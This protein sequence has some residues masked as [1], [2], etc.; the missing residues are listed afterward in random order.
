IGRE[1]KQAKYQT[2]HARRTSV[3]LFGVQHRID[4]FDQY[5]ELDANNLEAHVLFDLR[6][7][8]INEKNIFGSIA[9]RDDYHVNVTPC[10]FDYLYQVAVEEF[11][12]NIVGAKSANLATEVERVERLHD[13]FARFDFL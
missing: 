8:A 1:I 9:L 3:H 7:E 6:Q 4:R 10:Y 2:S 11:R 5:L 12:A 13:G